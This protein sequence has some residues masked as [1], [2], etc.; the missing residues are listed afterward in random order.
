MPD[1]FN[2]F[3]GMVPERKLTKEELIRVV[4]LDVAGE[5]EAI[6]GY[7][8]HAEA[9]DNELAK[10]VLTDIANEERV[11][12]G[13]LLRL[14]SILTGNEDE[15]YKKGT[16]EVDTLAGQIG[17]AGAAAPVTKEEPTIGSLKNTK[18]A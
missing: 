6:H 13:E 18:E 3:S 12:V 11:H 10:A 4:R 15:F 5:L 16:L 9:T 7:M 8:A 17:A 14:L 2:P 1:F